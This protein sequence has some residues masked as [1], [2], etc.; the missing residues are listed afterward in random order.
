MTEIT[1]TCWKVVKVGGWAP[2]LVFATHL[3]ID[4]VLNAYEWWPPIDSPMHFSGGL[5]IAFFVSRCFQTLP[6][7]DV[8]KGRLAILELLLVGS[9]TATTAVLWEFAEFS[10]DQLFGTNVQVSL[11][12]TMKDMALGIFGAVVLVGVR[13]AQLRAGADEIKELALDWVRGQAA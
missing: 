5:A 1:K 4:R 8:P 9:L 12:N 11:A 3:F 6:R 2:L 10:L 13:A 7:Q